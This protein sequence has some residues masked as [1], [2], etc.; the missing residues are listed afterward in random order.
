M[1]IIDKIL[2]CPHCG[3]DQHIN[4]DLS[5]GDQEYYDDCSA[6]CNPIHIRAHIDE[7]HHKVELYIDADDEQ[8]Y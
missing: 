2:S 4:I 3:H 7:Q 5:N 6:C 1:N 8:I